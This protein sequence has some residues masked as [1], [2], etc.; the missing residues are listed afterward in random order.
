[1]DDEVDLLCVSL[2]EEV[3]ELTGLGVVSDKSAKRF[4][5]NQLLKVD[6]FLVIRALREVIGIDDWG[7]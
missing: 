3:L 1:L 6:F 4:A 7:L 5:V 2:V